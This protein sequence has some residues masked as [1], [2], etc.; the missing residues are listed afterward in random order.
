[1]NNNYGLENGWIETQYGR[2]D[3]SNPSF[4]IRDIA[5]S[6]SQIARFNGHATRFYSVA[7]HSLMVSDLMES[8]GLGDPLEGLLHDASEAYLSDVPAPF[9]QFLPDWQKVDDSVEKALRSYWRLPER[10]SPGCK[11]ADWLA[12][13]IEAYHLL[14]SKGEIFFDPAKLRPEALKLIENGWTPRTH[15]SMT[16]TEEDFL[17]NYRGLYEFRFDKRAS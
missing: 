2:F 14:P 8:L 11:K 15:R 12:L 16:E 17:L 13:F 4:D 7:E 5:H 1:M 3:L 6:L 10:K 9:K